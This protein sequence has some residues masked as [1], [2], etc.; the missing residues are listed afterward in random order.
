MN[1]KLNWHVVTKEEI[2][3]NSLNS[4]SIIW[5]TK[6]H[7][8]NATISFSHTASDDTEP[9][10]VNTYRLPAEERNCRLTQCLC[11]YCAQP[12]HLRNS[13]L[14]RP[15][16]WNQRAVSIKIDALNPDMCVTVPITLSVNGQQ[17]A[18]S[19]LLDSGV[20]GN[21]MS[22]GFAQCIGTQYC[23]HRMFL[24]TVE[25]I[26]SRPLGT[27]H[28]T[29]LTQELVRR[30]GLPLPLRLSSSACQGFADIIH[31]SPRERVKLSIGIMPAIPNLP[32]HTFCHRWPSW[33]QS[34]LRGRGRR[35]QLWSWGHSLSVTR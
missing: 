12:G 23:P 29:A 1:Y 14:S 10:Q 30:T 8:Q 34:P 13:C 21:F 7:R 31:I 32:L 24:L 26:D 25:V 11:L 17:I 20:T 16:T 18:S 27:G 22:H 9:I 2:L 3:T 4:P 5:S 19:A 33:S 28:F 6:A 15:Q 35:H